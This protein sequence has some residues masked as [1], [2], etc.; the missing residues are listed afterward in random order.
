[1][2]F[3]P[4]VVYNVQRLFR[5]GGSRIARALDATAERGWTKA[6]YRRK[7]AAVGAMLSSATGGVRPALLVLIEVEDATVVADVCTAAGWPELVDLAD[8]HE[9]MDGYDVAVA[10]DPAEF[11]AAADIRSFTFE[12]RFA[13][14]D[15]LM[16]TLQLDQTHALTVVASHWASRM[17]SDAEILRIGAA[18]FCTNIL[19]GLVKFRKEDAFGPT[20]RPRLPSRQDLASRW[21]TPI[22][23]A[24]DLNDNPWD[25]SVGALLDA[26]PDMTLVARPPRFPRGRTTSSVAAYLRLR[27][28]LFNPTWE[29]ASPAAGVP[30]G[31]YRFGSDWYALDHV[32]V[33]A[34]LLGNDPPALRLGSLRVHGPSTVTA[35]DGTVIK[36]RAGDGTPLA[37]KAETGAGVSDHLPLVAELDL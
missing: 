15:L 20:G 14:R 37:F 2:A 31:T 29:L 32:L 21:S 7:I 27:P 36:A 19:E 17:M 35:Q 28:R 3:R 11:S 18:R 34:G 9:A 26:T 12:N 10:Y 8:P 25:R 6:V 16:A 30:R 24:G 22:L 13:T 23:F 4:I 1:V 5:P 33:S